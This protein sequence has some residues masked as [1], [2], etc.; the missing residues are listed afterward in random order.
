VKLISESSSVRSTPATTPRIESPVHG[1]TGSQP[2]ED[3]DV[4]AFLRRIKK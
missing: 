3:L 4:P 1:S 2:E